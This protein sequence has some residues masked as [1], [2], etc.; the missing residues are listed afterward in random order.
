MFESDGKC[1]ECPETM[2][3]CKEITGPTGAPIVSPIECV[4]GR[5]IGDGLES[6][7][8]ICKDGSY[9]LNG[10]LEC[11]PCIGECDTC[12]YASFYC[13]SCKTGFILDNEGKFCKCP[14]YNFMDVDTCKECHI[15]CFT[16]YDAD[17]KNC[18]LPT[19]P[20]SIVVGT[21]EESVL[22]IHYVF[23]IEN[24]EA[25]LEP[26]EKNSIDIFPGIDNKQ[27]LT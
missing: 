13:T 12:E 15:F 10:S 8:C 9:S 23:L 27:D 14:T 2:E 16:C 11:L 25:M 19:D 6:H 24:S 17:E 22:S 26:Y 1:E 5:R 21:N 4:E 18:I 20:N 7:E 3:T